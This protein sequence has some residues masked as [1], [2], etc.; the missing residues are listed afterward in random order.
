MVDDEV[1]PAQLTAERSIKGLAAPCFYT[2]TFG[3]PHCIPCWDAKL[4]HTTCEHGMV[5]KNG[6]GGWT[7]EAEL[8][9]INAIHS[10]GILG[11]K[12]AFTA[13]DEISHPPS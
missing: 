2:Y 11:L 13:G 7:V 8:D 12:L 9:W 3:M 1:I 10:A 5:H 4:H 6:T